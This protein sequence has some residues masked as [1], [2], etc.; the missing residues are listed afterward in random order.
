MFPLNDQNRKCQKSSE[1]LVSEFFI[2]GAVEKKKK[3]PGLYPR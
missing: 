3:T 2:A 1:K